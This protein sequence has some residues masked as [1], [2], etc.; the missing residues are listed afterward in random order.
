[1]A[2]KWQKI[3][4]FWPWRAEFCKNQKKAWTFSYFYP[5]EAVYQ[6]S[7]KL[8]HQTWKKC[9]TN[10]R[11]DGR[12]DERTKVPLCSTGLRPL[13]GHCPKTKKKFELNLLKIGKFTLY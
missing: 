12:T 7:E 6:I 13:R 1:M 11:T 8:A 5:K 3:D 9:V 4:V 10:G 2:K